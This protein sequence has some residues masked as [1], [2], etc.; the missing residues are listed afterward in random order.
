[1]ISILGIEQLDEFIIN[2]SDKILLLYFGAKRCSPCNILKER[3]INESNNEMPNLLVGY[4]D[5]DISENDEIAETYDVKMLPTQVFVKL[6]KD[7]VKIINRID[8]YDWIKLVMLYNE[9]A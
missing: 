4:I 5:V 6:K 2:N 7:R 1:M 9:I 3:I 8:G